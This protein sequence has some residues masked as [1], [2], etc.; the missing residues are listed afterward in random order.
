MKCKHT[1]SPTEP[2]LDK[3]ML[4]IL[5]QEALLL[6]H[7]CTASFVPPEVWL[8]SRLSRSSVQDVFT[9]SP[10]SLISSEWM[11]WDKTAS[12]SINLSLIGIQAFHVYI[13]ESKASSATILTWVREKQQERN[14]KAW[15]AA[16]FLSRNFIRRVALF[17]LY[18]VTALSWCQ[19][20]W[21]IAWCQSSWIDLRWSRPA[22]GPDQQFLARLTPS[23]ASHGHTQTPQGLFPLASRW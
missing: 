16:G 3:Q 2:L 11:T 4:L 5:C 17:I 1:L 12:Y 6:K 13:T 14:N 19:V 15:R 20:W 8:V 7:W 9:E 23:P 22:G 21:L 18:T 10:L